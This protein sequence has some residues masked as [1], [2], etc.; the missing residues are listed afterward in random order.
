M[1]DWIE[2]SPLAEPV[3]ASLRVPGSKSITNRALVTAALAG[4]RSRLRGALFSD[5]TRFMLDALRALGFAAAADEA[6]ASIEIEGL[7]ARIRAQEAELFVGNSGTTLPHLSAMV[8]LG[9]G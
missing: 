9:H 3:D 8:A 4:G 1:P 6:A 7:G 2:V 5:D